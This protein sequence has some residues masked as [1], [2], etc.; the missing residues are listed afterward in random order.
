MALALTVAAVACGSGGA[1]QRPLRL[2][3]APREV[4]A[5]SFLGDTL[6]LPA[7]TPDVRAEREAQ[8]ASAR[9][10]YEAAP[11][12]A[13]ALIWYGRRLAYLGRYRE[14]IAVFGRGIEDFPDDARMYRHRGHRYITVRQ[15]DSALS[16]LLRATQLTAGRPDEV[17]SD[18]LPNAAGVPTST[19]NSNIWYH[20]GLAHYLR[21]DFARAA[22]AYRECLT[23]APGADM[24]VAASHWLYMALRRLGDDAQA[25]TVLAPIR[26]DMAIIENQ[27]YHRLLLMYAG[28]VEPESLLAE[29]RVAG[30]LDNATLGYGIANWYLY[31]G[32]RERAD[33]LF[34]AILAGPEWAAFGFLAAEAEVARERRD[35]RPARNERSP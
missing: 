29:S 10:A 26:R 13:D 8:L 20:L 21:G 25:Q 15:L 2:P 3:A 28:A 16:D 12:D 34:A 17:E 30:T 27:S 14:A 22:S 9:A 5:V 33:T 11:G 1:A 7:L 23:Y 19:L 6:R 24:A 35:D 18:G 31:G 4:Q 32:D